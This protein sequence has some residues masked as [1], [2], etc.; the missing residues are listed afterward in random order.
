MIVTFVM[1][2]LCFVA[3]LVIEYKG[4]IRRKAEYRELEQFAEFLSDLKD[5]FYVCKNVTES[6]FRAAERVPGD[7]RKR[8]EEL[9]FLLETDAW[10]ITATEETVAGKLRY[11]R[12]F[13]IQCRSA[14][15]YGSGGN[16]TESVFQKNMTELRRDV[17]EECAA[18]TA[19]MYAF[20]GLGVITGVGA[21]FPPFIRKFGEFTIQGPASFY[22]GVGG[23]VTITAFL[24]ITV[25]CYLF[26]QTIRQSEELLRMPYPVF[27][28]K[29]GRGSEVM[30]LQAMIL[31]LL[32]V[33]EITVSDILDVLCSVA[34]RFRVPLLRC[35]DA[36]H[37]D[38]I[39]ALQQLY[40]EVRYP[41]FRR[42][43]ARLLMSDKV[44]LRE[45]F[46]DLATDRRYMRGQLRMQR[47]QERKKKVV[48]AQ[49]TAFVPLFFLLFAYLI[50]PFLTMS[51]GQMGQIFQQ[52]E[53]FR[54]S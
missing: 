11:M 36:Y 29:L 15:R 41:P 49:I 51:L 26:L 4:Y 38:D 33:P 30:E 32:D 34:Q 40:E 25:F 47:E 27:F 44:G 52:M 21:V 31:L 1:P 16:G 37:A 5:Y 54:I 42:L 23:Y 45:A 7:L 19:S 9:S 53:Q 24:L 10:G 6:I 18:K 35:K 3:V 13:V 28:R 46:S 43:I 12:A 17:Q 2:M 50:L 48:Y 22:G 14:I 20:A 8:L 39:A